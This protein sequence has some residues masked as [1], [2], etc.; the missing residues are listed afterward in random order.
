MLR[1]VALGVL[2]PEERLR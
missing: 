2:C 1:T